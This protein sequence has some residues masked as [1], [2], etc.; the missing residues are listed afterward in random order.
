MLSTLR[1][2]IV[3]TKWKCILCYIFNVYYSSPKVFQTEILQ[4]VSLLYEW[5]LEPL[6]MEICKIQTQPINT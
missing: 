1:V 2:V 5:V 6:Q 4:V 3:K